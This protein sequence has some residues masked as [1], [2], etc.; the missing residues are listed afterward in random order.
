MIIRTAGHRVNQTTSVFMADLALV[1]N[2]E[3][4]FGTDVVGNR[5]HNL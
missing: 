1:L 2:S 3:I 5:D 4:F